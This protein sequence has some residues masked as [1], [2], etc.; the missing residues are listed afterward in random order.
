M[1]NIGL[2]RNN[3]KE[4]GKYYDDDDDAKP[5]GLYCKAR[6]FSQLTCRTTMM[7]T[8]TMRPLW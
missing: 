3:G 1:A 6:C 2:S 4:H 5:Q 8:T 7:M